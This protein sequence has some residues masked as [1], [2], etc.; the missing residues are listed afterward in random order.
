MNDKL[1][2]EEV[3]HVSDLARIY[4]SEEE[5]E[6]YQVELKQ[7]LDDVEKIKDVK[8]YDDE[9][10][11]VPTEHTVTPREDVEKDTVEFNDLKA[12]IPNTFGNFVE[13]PV[14]INE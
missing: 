7:L 11:I 4:V 2:K 9:I 5:I 10:L 1:T 14:M 8:G 13:V 12:N 3:M 6:N